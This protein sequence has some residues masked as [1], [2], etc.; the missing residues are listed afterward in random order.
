M[1]WPCSLNWCAIGRLKRRRSLSPKKISRNLRATRHFSK[2]LTALP[3]VLAFRPPR[4][5]G[6]ACGTSRGNPRSFNKDKL[7][8]NQRLI[9]LPKRIIVRILDEHIGKL[10]LPNNETALEGQKKSHL[11]AICALSGYKHVQISMPL[12]SIEFLHQRSNLL[13]KLSWQVGEL[14]L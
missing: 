4:Q 3:L 11:C 8:E 5:T 2:V 14:S 10:H 7:A 12:L 9:S 1:K 6:F 13:G